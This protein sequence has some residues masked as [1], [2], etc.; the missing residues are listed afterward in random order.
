MRESESNNLCKIVSSMSF[1]K[2]ENQIY[3]ETISIDFSEHCTKN[4]S[5]R[6]EQKA[7]PL[8]H[9]FIIGIFSFGFNFLT[10]AEYVNFREIMRRIFQSET[11]ISLLLSCSLIALCLGVL[12]GGIIS[13]NLKTKFGGR[14]PTILL[15]SIIAALLLVIIPIFTEFLINSNTQFYLVL[16]VMISLHVSIGI[17]YAPWLALVPELFTKKQRTT[18]ALVITILS[19]IGAAIATISFSLLVDNNLH[20]LV[21]IITGV[22]IGIS[23]VLTAI[24][25]PKSMVAKKEKISLL[26]LLTLSR[27]VLQ[28]DKRKWILL[29]FVSSLWAFGTHIVETGMIDS[30]TERF[31]VSETK[32]SFASN[33]LMGVYI[34]I[35]ILPLLWLGK[36]MGKV[37]SSILASLFYGTFCL[38]LALMKNFSSIYCIVIVGGIGNILISTYQIA[39]PAD[40]VPKGFE[41]RFLGLFFVFGTATKP[42]ATFVHGLII[43]GN[44]TKITLN[45]FGGYPWLFLIAAIVILCSTILLLFLKKKKEELIDDKKSFAINI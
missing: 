25:I 3:T 17:A 9:F 24:F 11:T 21:W 12:I 32:A 28:S 38:L 34:A 33:I 27:E 8:K 42:L 43:E 20:W 45:P 15:G 7:T 31:N 6:V 23:G 5:E 26:K 30:L 1:E 44:V 41:A 37:K 14:A 19:A 16:L 36:K 22:L 10:T 35:M 2:D 39:L 18:A 40:V 4:E 29:L 13:D